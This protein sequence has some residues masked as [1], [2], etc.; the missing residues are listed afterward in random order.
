MNKVYILGPIHIF[1]E[2]HISFYKKLV[3]LTRK[4]F[5]EVLCTYPDFWDFKGSPREFYDMTVKKIT[6]AD[7]FIAEVSNPSHGVGMELQMA[8]ENK[9]PI[10]AVAKKEVELSSMVLGLPNIIKIIHYNSIED[11]TKSIKKELTNLKVK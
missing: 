9:I 6:D 4:Y 5:N 10:I 11:L 8:T 3:A 2:N 7:L 1:G